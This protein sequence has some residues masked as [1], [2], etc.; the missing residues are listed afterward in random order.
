[1]PFQYGSG[2]SNMPVNIASNNGSCWLSADMN[3]GKPHNNIYKITPAA[4]TSIC[5]I[6]YKWLL[7]SHD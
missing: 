7:K 2:N 5:R 1:M 4:Q 3:G 6:Y